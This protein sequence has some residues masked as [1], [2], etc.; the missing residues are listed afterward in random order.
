MQISTKKETA[1]EQDSETGTIRQI[2]NINQNRTL[3]FVF[4]QLNQ[5]YFSVISLVDF[6]IAFKAGD[7]YEE[8]SMYEVEDLLSKYIAD[9]KKEDVRKIL[10]KM[11]DVEKECEGKSGMQ[12]KGVK[13]NCK[14]VEQTNA[15]KVD[16]RRV[17]FTK[18]I[19]NQGDDKMKD[20]ENGG[21]EKW[22]YVREHTSTVTLD[23]KE[24][25]V[26]GVVVKV[27]RHIVKTD[28]F[29]T[30]SFL[31]KNDALDTFATELQKEAINERKANNSLI[32]SKQE[33]IR[34]IPNMLEKVADIFKKEG[35]KSGLLK[36]SN[37]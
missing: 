8:Y 13:T 28:G 32:D 11:L 1:T 4:T 16:Q 6:R 36:R 19:Q 30:E 17:S 20:S 18:D 3:N 21:G 31:G 35:K 33:A 10:R 9:E 22:E 27:D 34:S 25:N 29:V 23:K 26:K 12:L 24:S 2:E 37:N 15:K 7:V 5:E 14:E